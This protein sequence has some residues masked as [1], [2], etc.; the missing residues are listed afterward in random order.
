MLGED[1][2]DEEGE[3]AASPPSISPLG[4]LPPAYQ[5]GEQLSECKD[6]EKGKRDQCNLHYTKPD[7]TLVGLSLKY[8]VDVSFRTLSLDY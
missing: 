4:E 5:E 8:G 3:A 6:N 2:E 7:E 1:S